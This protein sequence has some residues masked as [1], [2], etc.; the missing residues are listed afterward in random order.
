MKTPGKEEYLQNNTIIS[1]ESERKPDNE[2][3]S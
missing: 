2:N 1:N 3:E